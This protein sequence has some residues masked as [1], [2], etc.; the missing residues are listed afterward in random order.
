MDSDVSS[1]DDGFRDIY[2]MLQ[3]EFL[4]R[5]RSERPILIRFDFSSM[6][7]LSFL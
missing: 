5:K 4:S 7:V 3:P 6:Y 2:L 1:D